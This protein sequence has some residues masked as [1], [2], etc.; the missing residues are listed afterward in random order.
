MSISVKN[1]SVSIAGT[2]SAE[3]DIELGGILYHL[4][5]FTLSQGLLAPNSLTFT[6]H[7]GPEEDIDEALFSLCGEIIGKEI[8]C[9]LM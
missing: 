6:I 1:I 8:E 5:N 3:F 9:G 4:D 2:K 7:K